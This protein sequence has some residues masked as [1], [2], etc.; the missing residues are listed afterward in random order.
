[1]Q[2]KRRREAQS[3]TWHS[4][5]IQWIAAGRQEGLSLKPVEL[6]FWLCFFNLVRALRGGW[7]IGQRHMK[8]QLGE[9]DP[10]DNGP[11][12]GLFPNMTVIFSASL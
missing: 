10:M 3:K 11:H 6:S 12:C 2:I 4:G 1:M 5:S 9:V 8:M 7:M